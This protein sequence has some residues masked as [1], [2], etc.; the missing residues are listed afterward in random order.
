MTC[1]HEDASYRLIKRSMITP[2]LVPGST[3][4]KVSGLWLVTNPNPSRG[5]H[6]KSNIQAA[7][8]PI[9]PPTRVTFLEGSLEHASLILALIDLGNGMRSMCSICSPMLAAIAG[10]SC[11]LSKS[12]DRSLCSISRSDI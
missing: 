6:H 1:A 5:P 4:L 9:P 12:S 7:K 3:I 10:S 2:N 8:C 11:P